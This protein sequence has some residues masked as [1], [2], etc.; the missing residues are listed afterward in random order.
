MERKTLLLELIAML[1]LLS[2]TEGGQEN[3]PIL[4]SAH[5]RQPQD[6]RYHSKNNSI[7][8]T[9]PMETDK[10]VG[11]TVYRCLTSS[12]NPNNCDDREAIQ[13][14][15]LNGL[16]TVFQFTQPMA[17][18][19]MAVVATYSDEV[20][21]G[22]KWSI[23]APPLKGKPNIKWTI[24]GCAILALLVLCWIIILKLRHMSEIRVEL[25]DFSLKE[26]LSRRISTSSDVSDPT[27]VPSFE[28]LIS[29]IG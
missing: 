8:W 16:H 9:H 29:K 10:L 12:G 23:S 7:T 2:I 15:I 27:P 25:P 18:Y 28:K 26:R 21:G 1:T 19:R 6:V 13:S 3:V 17:L 22:L 20:S 24:V 14:D 4:D 11:Y 5:S